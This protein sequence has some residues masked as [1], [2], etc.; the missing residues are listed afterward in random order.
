MEVLEV[1]VL[2]LLETGS[3]VHQHILCLFIISYHTYVCEVRLRYRIILL[4]HFMLDSEVLSSKLDTSRRPA[5]VLNPLPQI[6]VEP[7]HGVSH[8]NQIGF[9]GHLF[10]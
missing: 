7:T 3:F 4:G 2:L 9:Y 8:D 1:K 6:D 10:V 5:G